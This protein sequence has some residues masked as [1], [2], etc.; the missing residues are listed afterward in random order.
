M[1]EAAIFTIHSFCQRMLDRFRFETGRLH[2]PKLIEDEQV[3]KQQAVEDYWREQIYSAPKARIRFIHDFCTSPVDLTT[4]IHRWL[5]RP[6]P[7][8]LPV[9]EEFRYLAKQFYHNAKPDKKSM[10]YR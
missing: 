2:L 7:D 1:D 6:C 3:L 10:A 8:S 4:K 9:V 5:S